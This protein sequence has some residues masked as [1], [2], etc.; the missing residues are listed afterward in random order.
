MYKIY[1]YLCTFEYFYTEKLL[2]RLSRQ[3]L[4]LIVNFCRSILIP[5]RTHIGTVASLLTTEINYTSV[6]MDCN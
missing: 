4:N 2:N 1:V 3:L 5:P 6:N